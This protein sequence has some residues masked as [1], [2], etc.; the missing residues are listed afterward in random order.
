[1]R[2]HLSAFNEVDTPQVAARFSIELEL[3][4][5]KSGT[6][7]WTQSYIHDEPVSTKNVPAVVDALQTNVRTGLQQL[8]SSLSQYFASQ[9]AH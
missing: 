3:F 6:L 1:L 2:G 4:E 7:V 8:T 9:G 5:R